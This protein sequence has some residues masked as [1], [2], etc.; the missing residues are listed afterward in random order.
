MILLMSLV[1]NSV[2]DLFTLLNEDGVNNLLA[3]SRRDA[4]GTLVPVCPDIEVQ[5]SNLCC[6]PQQHA[7][8]SD[9]HGTRQQPWSH[10]QQYENED[11]WTLA[12]HG[13]RF[14]CFGD[15]VTLLVFLVM[16]MGTIMLLVL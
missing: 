8:D 4:C 11:S 3:S 16:T 13:S 1:T 10:V 5:C 15:F 6:Q 14:L 9:R 2:D 7:C 12:P